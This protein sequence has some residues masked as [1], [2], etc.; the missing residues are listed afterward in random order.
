MRYLI[1]V[2]GLLLA[3]LVGMPAADAPRFVYI[4]PVD[5]D[6]EGAEHSRCLGM[7]GMGNI[8]L[9]S[10][11]IDGFL[12]Q[13]DELPKDMRGVT[14]LGASLTATLDSAK[15]TDLDT[16]AHK[17][18]AALKVNE[19]IVELLSPRLRAGRDGKLKIYLGGRTPIYQQTAG[20]PFP[21]HGL[22][23]DVALGVVYVASAVERYTLGAVVAYAASVTEDFNC[24]DHASILTCDLTWTNVTGTWQISSN[25]ALRT[26][27]GTARIRADSP[28]DTDDFEVSVSLI[29]LTNTGAGTGLCAV[30]A[31]KD[32]GA[33]TTNYAFGANNDNGVSGYQIDKVLAGTR[34]TLGTNTQDQVDNDLVLLR[35]DGSTISGLVNGTEIVTVTDTDITGNTYGGVYATSAA[36]T[37]SCTWDNWAAADYTAPA[38]T[39]R[40]R[41]F[42]WFN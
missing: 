34:T 17:T 13:S 26:A 16:L 12:C 23:A 42:L 18:I 28:M 35:V 10:S 4:S 38:A 2:L 7:S 24:A 5:V 11:G 27:T 6:G 25:Q 14:Q 37:F 32:S 33:T 31:R 8:D 21:D 39:G 36:S 22:F 40:N 3:G 15:K 19:L 1:A 29:D 41:G 30:M 9:R 20:V